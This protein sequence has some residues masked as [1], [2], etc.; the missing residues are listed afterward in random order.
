[1]SEQ[2][3]TLRS[4]PT[5]I[6]HVDGDA[7]F[8]SVEQAVHPEWRG[9]PMVTGKE[10]NIIACAS[11]EAKALGIKRGLALTPVQFGISFTLQHLN[12]AG[13]LV[14]VYR[15]GS[16]HLSHGGT[17]MGQGLFQKVAQ[18]TASVFGI[19]A[20]A[21]KITATDTAKVP[22]TSATAASSGG[23]GWPRASRATSARSASRSRPSRDGDRRPRRDEAEVESQ[24]EVDV[25]TGLDRDEFQPDS[26][27]TRHG[28]WTSEHADG[29]HRREQ[30][31][32]ALLGVGAA[33]ESAHVVLGGLEHP[34]IVRPSRLQPI[35]RTP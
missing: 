30:G 27:R 22:N 14:H 16:I 8:T 19:D 4:F 28:W 7:F 2:P 18:V 5:A 11:Y 26:R 17:E 10:R 6:L 31:G 29:F 13:A 34:T 23:N 21:V 3:F 25:I 12:Q 33:E 1:M 32:A 35:D 20:S 9:K 24:V 15:D